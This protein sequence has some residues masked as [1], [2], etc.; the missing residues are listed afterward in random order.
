[1]ALTL[2]NFFGKVFILI[3][4][5]AGAPAINSRGF[6]QVKGPAF[7]LED[8]EKNLG[9][10][11]EVEIVEIEY[12]FENTGYQ[13]III[14]EIKVTCGCTAG[15]YPKEP[16]LPGKKGVIKIS[17]DTKGKLDR[18]DRTV[19]VISNVPGPP[20]ELRFKGVVL[21]KK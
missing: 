6:S 5:F 2:N 20:E 18:Q 3:F 16:V 13:P 17:F 21:K 12:V 15:E 19:G 9:F 14:Q 11:M 8:K 10:V 1:M 7:Q 4:L